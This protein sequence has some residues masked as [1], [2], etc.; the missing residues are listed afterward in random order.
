[1]AAVDRYTGAME[2][3]ELRM[4]LASAIRLIRPLS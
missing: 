3:E 1:M 4:L 2:A